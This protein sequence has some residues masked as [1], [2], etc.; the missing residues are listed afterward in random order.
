M[1]TKELAVIIP[2][3]NEEEIIEQVIR[4]WDAHLD[5]LGI[6]YE[7]HIYND[8]SRDNTAAVLASLGLPRVIS[9]NKVNSGHGPTILQGY[10]DNSD[11]P[12]I[13]QID[14]D[15]EL[16]ITW[17][18]ELWEH[19]KD[20]DLLLGNRIKRDSPLPRKIITF[21]SWFTVRF[22]YGKGISDANCPYR[23]MRSDEGLRKLFTAI[24][25]DT[26]TPNIIL[27]GYFCKTGKKIYQVPVSFKPRTTGK[28]SLVKFKL[29]T[30]SILAFF[31]VIRFRNKIPF[32]YTDTE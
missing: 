23:L 1:E 31:Q 21:I 8:G 7:I 18:S 24:P 27:S 25:T 10:R 4:K 9:H 32:D 30:F 26:R 11:T 19:R 29:I 16:D 14:S 12:W 3:Y 22:F 6:L 20:Y 17:F 13:F 5:A 28:P 2:V 15:D